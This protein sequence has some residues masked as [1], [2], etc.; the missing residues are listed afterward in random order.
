MKKTLKKELDFSIETEREGEEKKA[1]KPQW[2]LGLSALCGFLFSQCDFFISPFS[3]SFVAALSFEYCFSAFVG[4]AIGYFC[5][6]GITEA[7]KYTAAVFAVAVFRLVKEKYF[8]LTEE[9]FINGIFAFSSVFVTGLV[10]Y[11]VSEGEFLDLITLSF[12][13][14][15]AFLFSLLYI[16]LRKI[17]FMRIGLAELS[18]KDSLCLLFSFCSFIMCSGGFEVEGLSPARI[19]SAVLILFFSL[20]NG[21][22][23][24]APLGVA[25]ALSLSL[26]GERSFI[27]AAYSLG[28]LFSG[29]VSPFGQTASAVVFALVGSAAS[30]FEGEKGIISV[31]EIVIASAVFIILPSKYIG[32]FGE[33]LQKKGLTLETEVF[34]EVSENLHLAAEN[35][36]EVT[37]IVLSVSEKLDK[38]IDPEVNRLFSFLQQRVCDGCEK[39][40]LCWNK[41]F[42]STASDILVIAGIENG[43]KPALRKNCLR[44]ESLYKYIS[45]GYSE[46]AESLSAK[47]KSA[48]MRKSLTDQFSGMGDFLESTAIAISESRNYDKGKSESLK[49]VLSDSGIFVEGLKLFKDRESK[50]RIEITAL[51][52]EV[53]EQHKKIKAFM[54]F[55]LK[56]SFENAKITTGEMKILIVF[57]EKTAFK[58]QVGVAQKALFEKNV[59]GDTVVSAN[60][61]SG[62][63]ITIL[64]DGMGTG[65]RAKIDSAMTCSIMEKLL[66]GGFD[67]ESTLKIVNSS[68]IMKSTDESISTVDA[69]KV[70]LYT[71]ETEFFKAGAALSIIRQGNEITTVEGVSLPVGIIRN[72]K[73]FKKKKQLSEGDIVLLLSDGALGENCGWVHD[74]LLSWSTNSMNDLAAHIVKLASLRQSEATKDDITVVA[75]KINKNR[76]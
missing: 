19:F 65:A 43:K 33:F 66:S 27:F 71:A 46:Y 39:K 13:S 25:I 1:P 69:V 7:F 17:P 4:S 32:H 48:E 49:A 35:I 6:M 56:R 64:S 34:S 76:D 59:C 9:N 58:V 45:E 47:M 3:V 63:K 44:F 55:V 20:Y 40:S 73:P 2:E 31:I 15:I 22:V 52:P 10:Y 53:S 54:E 74:E 51:D 42:D 61:G 36:K 57:E 14:V 12:E 29:V 38:I 24:S 62:S 50:L 70:N 41:N 16:R 8:R 21:V 23:A 37:D 60:V 26:S 72:I 18:V 28:A 5:T 68:L 30:A 75:V 67:F 11:F